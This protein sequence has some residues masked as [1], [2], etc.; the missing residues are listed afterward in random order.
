VKKE[1]PLEQKKETCAREAGDYWLPASESIEIHICQ[2]LVMATSGHRVVLAWSPTV[3][4]TNNRLL[5]A[6]SLR[7]VAQRSLSGHDFPI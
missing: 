1:V 5:V 3:S 7:P 6:G 2:L 4:A